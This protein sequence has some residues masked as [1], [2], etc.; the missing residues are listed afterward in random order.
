VD[1]VAESV[2]IP[3]GLAE[4]AATAPARQ[5][6]SGSR[7][8]II[9]TTKSGGLVSTVTGT[10][11]VKDV[12]AE[13]V[14]A[15]KVADTGTR[16]PLDSKALKALVSSSLR[17]EAS[18]V[19]LASRVGL[20]VDEFIASLQRTVLEPGT[21]SFTDAEMDVF[22][23]AHVDL[24]GPAESAGGVALA[25]RAAAHRLVA[26]ALTVDEA[27]VALGVT[28]GRVRQRLSA[29]ELLH[30]R[31]SDGQAVI[32]RWQVREGRIVPGLKELFGPAPQLHPLAVARFMT[33][34]HPDLEL[35]EEPVSPSDWLLTGGDL[36]PVLEL[37]H[38]VA[39]RG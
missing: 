33:A 35:D 32:P 29:G 38:S 24:T 9:E 13:Q 12:K 3:V 27:A 1:P 7:T 10:S 5:K 16:F 11:P 22:A 6:R 21:S 26:E 30:L 18:L 4:A 34:A 25:G 17:H 23:A 15:F 37:L 14:V 8:R 20:S 31:R 39:L 36:E 2:E 19:E 28:P